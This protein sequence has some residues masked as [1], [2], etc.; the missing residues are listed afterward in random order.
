MANVCSKSTTVAQ[1]FLEKF[2]GYRSDAVLDT[3]VSSSDVNKI[4]NTLYSAKENGRN[5]VGKLNE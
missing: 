4:L 2:F 1:Y 5:Q 3:Q